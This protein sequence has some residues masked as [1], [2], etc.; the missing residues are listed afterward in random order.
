MSS[1]ICRRRGQGH[2]GQ[3]TVL[4]ARWKHLSTAML[5]LCLAGA[6]TLAACERRAQPA[7]G[8]FAATAEA[9]LQTIP[10]LRLYL[11]ST[12]A[13]A[14]EPCGCRKDMLGGVDHAAALIKQGA[15]EAPHGLVLAAGPLFFMEPEV[16]AANLTKDQQD[17]WKADAIA[18]ALAKWD[19]QAWSPGV[20]DFGRGPETLNSLKRTTGSSMLAANLASPGT[21][22]QAT[23]V[24]ER[25][26]V[27]VGLTGITALG[28]TAIHVGTVGAEQTVTLTQSDPVA[29]LQNASKQLDADGAAVKIVLISAPR[30]EAMRLLE[31]VPA[32]DVAVIGKPKD[33]GDNND[34]PIPPAVVGKTLVVQGPNHLQAMPIVDLFIRG[35]KSVRSEFTDASGIAVEERRITLQARIKELSKRIEQ[36]RAGGTVAAADIAAREVDLASMSTELET[37]PQ[38]APPKSGNYFRYHIREVREGLGSEVEVFE[39]IRRY[40]KQVNEHNRVAFK[41]RKPVAADKGKATFVGGAKCESCHQEAVAF[42][43]TTRHANAYKTLED[44]FKEFNLDCVGCHVT[45][46]EMP[47][48]STVTFVEGLK[49][50]QCE[51]CHA[52]GSI[53]VREEDSQFITLT[54]PETLCSKCHHPPHVADDWDVKAAWKQ[55]IGPGH[56][57]P[58][59]KSAPASESAAP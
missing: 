41:D 49:D 40:Y 48:G 9:T 37:L 24:V 23:R 34:A 44:D 29:A 33:A 32:F 2:V 19:L 3:H 26:G 42:W 56:G 10:S 43:E 17:R 31:A 38:A 14:M 57:E 11:V 12:L 47:G 46:Y 52:P 53:H 5:G 28:T 50:V 25:G 13:G 8:E 55:I 59:A 16:N 45:G 54:P 39:R 6:A 35:D 20:N 58:L 36:W 27:R 15:T 22:I 18:N 30:G 4:G 1:E 51:V 21:E 7:T